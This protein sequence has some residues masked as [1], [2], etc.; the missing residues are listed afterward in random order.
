VLPGDIGIELAR[1]ITAAVAT[2][3][4][5]PAAAGT[6][7]AGTWRPAPGA[8]P[9]TYSSSL[10]FQLAA[11]A[12]RSVGDM[13]ALLAAGLR[14]RDW[15]SDAAVTG[16]GYLT[17][18]PTAAA[19]GALAVRVSL[20]G[21][22]C[23]RSDAL[24]SLSLRAPADADLVTAPTWVQAHRRLAAVMSGRLAQAAGAR[25]IFRQDCERIVPGAAEA[26]PPAGPAAAVIAFAG[27]DAVRYAL[28]R[29]PAA[30]CAGIDAAESVQ[31]VLGN[32]FYAVSFA[33]ADA[34]A[35]LCRGAGAGRH[36]GEPAAFRPGLLAC[37]AERALLGTISWL[38]ER[39]AGAARRR[40][41]H[42]L[43]RYLEELAGAYL[44]VR[45]SCPALPSGGLAAP[46]DAATASAR[47]WL[48]AAAGASI[49]AG[50]GLL[51]VRGPGLPCCPG[52]AIGVQTGPAAIAG[53]SNSWPAV[54]IQ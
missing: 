5:P 21:P 20:A 29:I 40:Q 18:T 8:E 41:P 1:V 46:R 45:E 42:E 10:P 27:A 3:E 54:V 49:G 38:P 44:D 47:L 31:H 4:L 19:L 11:L 36:R 6:T 2:A 53:G 30:R 34:A 37:P 50:L 14:R 43:A 24:R 23:A 39:V 17:V 51:G 52:P 16:P 15:I 9:G 48:A 22:D 25:V 12:G 35:T 7:S 13:A 33:H 26:E 28:A 32:P